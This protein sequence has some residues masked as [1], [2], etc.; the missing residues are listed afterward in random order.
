MVV[1][2]ACPP[3]FDLP[4]RLPPNPIPLQI[5][6]LEAYQH[7][8]IDLHIRNGLPVGGHKTTPENVV[9]FGQQPACG[10]FL[11]RSCLEEASTRLSFQDPTILHRLAL[12]DFFP[13]EEVDKLVSPDS[14]MHVLAVTLSERP[15][16]KRVIQKDP[17]AFEEVYISQRDK[18]HNYM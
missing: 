5:S 10:E 17:D 18:V 1:D 13:K 8:W 4:D 6:F 16:I 11:R 3:G 12:M 7:N 2:C 14:P 9:A 15:L